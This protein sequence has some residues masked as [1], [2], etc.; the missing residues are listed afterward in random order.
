MLNTSEHIGKILREDVY[1][2]EDASEGE[3]IGSVLVSAHCEMTN[4][5]I[6]DRLKCEQ[7]VLA[8]IVDILMANDTEDIEQDS[9]T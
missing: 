7:C 2:D 1:A 8:A 4:E 5:V 9:K 6:E 3:N